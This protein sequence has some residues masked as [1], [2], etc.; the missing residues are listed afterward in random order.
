MNVNIDTEQKR[1]GTVW[2]NHVEVSDRSCQKRLSIIISCI[3]MS[4]LKY[5]IN[6]LFLDICL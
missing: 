1:T 5:T 2:W 4:A 3:E 6:Q